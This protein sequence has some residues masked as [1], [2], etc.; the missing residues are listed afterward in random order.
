M[1]KR[2]A[3]IGTRYPQKGKNITKTRQQNYVNMQNSHVIANGAANG[4]GKVSYLHAFF[5]FSSFICLFLFLAE[6]EPEE[7]LCIRQIFDTIDSERILST[8]PKHWEIIDH[9]W[10]IYDNH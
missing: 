7:N 8:V 9:F 6:I 3:L 1:R 10:D 4:C 2:P 5:L